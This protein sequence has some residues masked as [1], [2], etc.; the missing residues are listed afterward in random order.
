MCSDHLADGVSIDKPRKE[1]KGHE[2][3]V[4]DFWVEG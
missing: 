1:D 4:E 2:M 3:V